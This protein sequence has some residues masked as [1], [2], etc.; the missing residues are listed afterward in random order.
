MDSTSTA[1]WTERR[2]ARRKSEVQMDWCVEERKPISSEDS[3]YQG[4]LEAG[5]LMPIHGNET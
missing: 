2:Q 3:L 1:W 5:G 4:P